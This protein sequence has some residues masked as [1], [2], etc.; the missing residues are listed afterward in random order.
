MIRSI[1]DLFK[2]PVTATNEQAEKATL[3]DAFI[4]GG[5]IS[6]IFMICN[7]V[8]CFFSQ[9][10]DE[11]YDSKVHKYVTKIDFS[12]FKFGELISNCFTTFIVIAIAMIVVA[13]IMYVIS[14]IL[15]NEN[16]FSKVLTI[17]VNAFI[18]L[19]CAN[20]IAVVIGWIYTPVIPILAYLVAAVYSLYLTIFSFRN[21]LNIEN[22]DKLVIVNVVAVT[23]CFVVLY[24]LVSVVFNDVIDLLD[25]FKF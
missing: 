10:L 21:I 3:K 16:A 1:I 15:K 11:K 2:R 24:F 19:A 9:I 17:S 5:I 25:M 12:G 13:T 20:I 4:K 7:F 6:V 23:I 18:P 22:E 14:R 8:T